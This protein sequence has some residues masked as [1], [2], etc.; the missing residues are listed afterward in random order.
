MA[1]DIAEVIERSGL[2]AAT[3]R[4]YES[5]G[6]IEPSGRRGLRRQY[7][8]DVLDRLALIGLGRD[9]GFAL[10]EIGA[11]LPL[12]ARPELDRSK[13]EARADELDATIE[14]LIVVRDNL[15][16]AAR[17]PAPNHLDCETFRGLMDD[18]RARRTG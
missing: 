6:L 17:C 10:D 14:W 13:L 15:R 4:H 8:E 5:K 1:L 7:D 16:H 3:L 12:D 11:M 9:A 18:A 2:T